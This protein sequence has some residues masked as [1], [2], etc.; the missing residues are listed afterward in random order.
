MYNLILDSKVKASWW[1]VVKDLLV[2]RQSQ[3]KDW[4]DE[5]QDSEHTAAAFMPGLEQHFSDLERRVI[6]LAERGGKTLSPLYEDMF[7]THIRIFQDSGLST[8]SQVLQRFVTDIEG[9][10]RHLL[11]VNYL[12]LLYR[13]AAELG[14][15]K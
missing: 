6:E 14:M 5:P 9:G 1:K 3:H 8:L 2:A 7:K 4:D 11:S 10:A 12:L 15:W 13:Q